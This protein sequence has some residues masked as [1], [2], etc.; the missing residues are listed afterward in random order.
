MPN[1][2]IHPYSKPSMWRRMSFA[3]WK[4]PTDP[5]VYGRLEIDL[6]KALEYLGDESNR[7]GMRIT[8]THLAVRALSLALAEYPEANTIIR[9]RRVYLRK[10]VDIFCQVAIPGDKPDLSGTVIRGADKLGIAGIAEALSRQA[11]AVKTGG[12]TEVAK[13]RRNLDMLPGILYRP[14]L[15]LISLL[16]YTLNIDVRVIGLPR[17]PFGGAMVTSVGSL[18]IPEGWA[19]LVPMS[20]TPIVICVG[21]I[22]DKPVA[23]NGAVEIHPVCVFNA[24]FD[25]R[26]MDGFLGGKLTTFIRSYLEDPAA[27]EAGL[28]TQDGP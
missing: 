27:F 17:D 3:N 24:V 2:P 8:P 11:E 20:K 18:G 14:V 13:A 19:P 22:N 6:K 12:D 26:I 21:E 23:V 10:N 9:W 16:Q 7:R 28:S 5:Q 1:I 4:N 15:S 25:H